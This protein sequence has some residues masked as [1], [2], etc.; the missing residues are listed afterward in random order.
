MTLNQKFQMMWCFKSN[1]CP[2]LTWRQ[3]QITMISK[4]KINCLK[5]HGIS[6]YNKHYTELLRSPFITFVEKKDI[7][8]K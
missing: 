1:E 2:D 6:F 5:Q 4:F 3:I 7:L 8:T